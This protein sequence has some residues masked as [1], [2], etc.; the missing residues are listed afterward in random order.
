MPS[1]L[2]MFFIYRNEYR[3]LRL[4]QE[5]FRSR[6]YPELLSGQTLIVTDVPRKF[7]SD[8]GIRDVIDFSRW[9]VVRHLWPGHVLYLSQ[10]IPYAPPLPGVVPLPR[11]PQ[12]AFWADA[13][14]ISCLD[15]FFI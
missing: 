11:I 4:R 2:V 13:H 12:I 3:M 1:G 7:Q 14:I 5:W 10:L 8:E 9:Y 6:E 15:M